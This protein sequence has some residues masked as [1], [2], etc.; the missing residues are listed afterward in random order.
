MKLGGQGWLPRQLPVRNVQELATCPERLIE[1]NLKR[2]IRLDGQDD[3]VA[4]E[5]SGEVP[6]IDL[7]KLFD[8]EFAEDESARL[9]S[10]CEDWGFFHVHTQLNL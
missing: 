3:E 9:R 5:Q 1:E 8:P 2:Y 7:G 10:A 4:A 6:M